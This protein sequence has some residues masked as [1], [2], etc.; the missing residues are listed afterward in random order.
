[1]D[2]NLIRKSNLDRSR[3]NQSQLLFASRKEGGERMAAS[4]ATSR[5]APWY[6]GMHGTVRDRTVPAHSCSFL[7]IAGCSRR[8]R[9]KKVACVWPASPLPGVQFLRCSSKSLACPRMAEERRGRLA[10]TQCERRKRACGVSETGAG[11]TACDF[12]ARQWAHFVE[13]C[14]PVGTGADSTTLLG[15]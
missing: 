15:D 14:G 12:C 4:A 5:I 8:C 3:R 11:F 10:C 1:M 13:L 7:R 6:V 2:S 9:V